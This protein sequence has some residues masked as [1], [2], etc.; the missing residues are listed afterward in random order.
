[1]QIHTE[2]LVIR[3]SDTGENDRIVTILTKDYGIVRAFAN[4]A[5]KL[6]SRSQSATQLLSY[7][8]FSIYCG[9]DHNTIN[10][11]QSIE[12]F[13]KLREDIKRLTLAQYFCE[14]AGELA[15]ESD[16]AEDYL[17]LMLNS[18]HFLAAGTRPQALLKAVTELR[19]LCLAGYMPDLVACTDCGKYEDTVMHFDCENGHLRCEPCG[20]GGIPLGLGLLTAMRHI[21]YAEFVRVYAFTLPDE[22]MDHLA[23]ITGCYLAAHVHKPFKTLEFYRTLRGG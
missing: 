18:L 6:K 12:V 20:G 13:F 11:A 22:S 8:R 14:L 23:E 21:C 16:E 5:K 4:G 10:E 7:G 19:M 2:G 17:K 1:M 9:R 15:P 3:Q